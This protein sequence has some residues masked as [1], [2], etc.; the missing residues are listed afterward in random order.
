[1]K[2]LFINDLL[3][4]TLSAAN[5]NASYPVTNLAHVFLKK[6]YKSSSNVDVVSASWASDRVVNSCFIGFTNAGTAVLKLYNAAGALLSTKSINP[7]EGAAHFAAVSGVR[8]A[9]LELTRTIGA[10]YLGGVGIGNAYTMPDPL[11]DWKDG[12]LDSSTKTRSP[13]GQVLINKVQAMR[14]MDLNFNVAD[15]AEF[16][17]IKALVD[18]IDRPVYADVFESAH[19]KYL[20]LYCDVDGG[21]GSPGKS[22]NEF[23]FSL[24]LVEAR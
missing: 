15:Y 6:I 12:T 17:E 8:I 18:A 23:T 14:Q 22:D 1:M 19:S 2:I 4:A 21:F 5:T 11:A 3:T 20:A 24:S 7:T 16:S 10:I 13:S 9:T